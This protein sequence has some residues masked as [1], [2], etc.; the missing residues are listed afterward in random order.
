MDG[1]RLDNKDILKRIKGV[2]DEYEDTVPMEEYLLLVKEYK[3]LCVKFEKLLQKERERN[4]KFVNV[5]RELTA[6]YE[7]EIKELS[8]Q[9][10]EYKRENLQYRTLLKEKGLLG[11]NKEDRPV[12]K[13]EIHK[14][15]EKHFP[16]EKIK[17]LLVDVVDDLTNSV[18]DFHKIKLSFFDDNKVLLLQRAIYKRVMVITE[19]DDPQ[20]LT[21]ITNTILREHFVFVHRELAK[22]VLEASAVNH[23]VFKFLENQFIEIDEES[24]RW[25]NFAVMRFMKEY[26]YKQKTMLKLKEKLTKAVE[27]LELLEK[28]TDENSEDI[29]DYKQ[30][31]RAKKRLEREIRSIKYELAELEQEF[32]SSYRENY[33]LLLEGVTKFLLEKRISIKMQ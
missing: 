28:S 8:L 24:E 21:A 11:N 19:I 3:E 18:L 25:N 16:S 12:L 27:K 32:N 13:P 4:H 10:E 26:L 14:I 2:L 5:K 9:I 1:N 20:I 15:I 33:Q 6:K 17:E 30:K 7:N 29:Q 22:R 31:S 23:G